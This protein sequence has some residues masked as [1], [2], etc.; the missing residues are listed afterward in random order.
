MVCSLLTRQILQSLV[1][2]QSVRSA[3]DFL[4]T[5]STMTSMQDTYLKL[6]CSRFPNPKSNGQGT[7]QVKGPSSFYNIKMEKDEGWLL[8]QYTQTRRPES[9]LQNYLN[10][11]DPSPSVW[12]CRNQLPQ[13]LILPT[14]SSWLGIMASI[15]RSKSVYF[16]I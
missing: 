2:P 5:P 15:P 1:K 16:V 7:K 12:H 3:F 13:A 14:S 9:E 10:T 8:V 11:L 6:P 4:N